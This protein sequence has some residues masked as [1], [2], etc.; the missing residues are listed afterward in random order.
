MADQVMRMPAHDDIS[1]TTSPVAVRRKCAMCED[2]LQRSEVA[3]DHSAPTVDVATEQAINS[4]S[5]RGHALPESVRSFVEPRFN[6]DFSAVRIH[7]DADAQRLA[8]S[9][10]AQAF[11]VGRNVVFGAG[12]YA[13]E[14]DAGK[15]LL[16]HELTHVVQQAG[17]ASRTSAVVQRRPQPAPPRPVNTSKQFDLLNEIQIEINRSRP[18]EARLTE[19]FTALEPSYAAL[20]DQAI[21]SGKLSFQKL[22]ADA[23]KRLRALVTQRKAAVPV[24]APGV[25]GRGVRRLNEWDYFIVRH[26]VTIDEIANYLSDDPK[27]PSILEARNAIPHDKVLA[28]GTLV[29]FQRD[30]FKRPSAKKQLSENLRSGSFIYPWGAFTVSH[31]EPRTVHRE[32]V[33]LTKSE[34]ESIQENE[35]EQKHGAEA[36]EKIA[37]KAKADRAKR[38]KTDVK[39]AQKVPNAAL[40]FFFPTSRLYFKDQSSLINDPL[41]RFQYQTN[42]RGFDAGTNLYREAGAVAVAANLAPLAILE[43][44]AAVGL[45]AE[46]G[47]G[48]KLA[49]G[50]RYV[51]LNAPTLYG[52]AMFYG[53]ASLTGAALGQHVLEL[54]SRGFEFEWS[55]LPRLAQDLAPFFG[56]WSESQNMRR[57]TTPTLPDAPDPPPSAHT[58]LTAPPQPPGPRW[59]RDL[60]LAGKLTADDVIAE[61]GNIAGGG[62]YGRSTPALVQNAP[63][64]TT[65]APIRTTDPAT[66]PDLPS[67]PAITTSRPVA[68]NAPPTVTR[69]TLLTPA[70]YLTLSPDVAPPTDVAPL[71]NVAP[72]VTPPVVTSPPPVAT[73]TAPAGINTTTSEKAADLGFRDA[74]HVRAVVIDALSKLKTGM[75][76]A[77]LPREY[78]DVVATLKAGTAL[79]EK[80]LLKHIDAIVG[81]LRNP[82]LY[83]DV[84]ADAYQIARANN[85]TIEEGLL[86]LARKE[87][88]TIK[89]IPNQKGILEGGTF[90]DDYVKQRVSIHDLPFKADPNAPL[91]VE[92]HGS[93]IHIVQDIVVNRARVGRTSYGFRELLGKADRKI[94]ITNLDGEREEVTVGDYVWRN[95]YDLFA[96]GHMP[97]PEMIGHV[98]LRLLKVR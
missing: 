15:R 47:A 7:T 17:G 18:R 12:R 36:L 39:R 28:A 23:G 27:L 85:L 92:Y 54:R 43:G 84:M 83:G 34:W 58:N 67:V 94:T 90:F 88:L 53:G 4:L 20:V 75:D 25:Y 66:R 97:M 22:P 57:A 48:A 55:D 13:P 31:T 24:L 95:T 52:D 56:G 14:S 62:N 79:P 70:P 44:Y 60:Y 72:D 64:V 68:A 37:A 89:A 26:G 86:D 33:L 3:S 93:V 11:T 51:Y 96:R 82:E 59:L 81:A 76:A 45:L 63:R 73:V 87:G 41:L 16:A 65:A 91:P 21:V 1:T 10:D 71:V 6:A 42:L 8:R 32:D 69:P 78:L 5:G 40:T 61:H 19:V 38:L 29:Y 46:A 30:S 74:A 9:V 49:Y 35:L 77:S 80:E 98:L 50:A 2:E